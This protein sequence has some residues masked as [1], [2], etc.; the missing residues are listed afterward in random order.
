MS[1]PALNSGNVRVAGTGSL[2]KAPLGTALPI[3]STTAWGSGFVN[4]GYVTDGFS[5]KQSLKKQAIPVWQRLGSVRSIVTELIRSLTFEAVESKTETV[6]LAWGGATMTP[7]LA[8]I[9]TLDIPEGQ[10][11]DFIIGVDWSDGSVT[12]RFVVQRASLLN[13]PEMKF[14]RTDAVRYPFEVEALVPDDGTKSILVYGV[15]SAVS[16]V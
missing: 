9:Y 3:D 14:I 10:L 8:G 12:Q 5:V 6:S 2:W 4:L 11:T 15:D 7:G 16:G 13:L 1:T